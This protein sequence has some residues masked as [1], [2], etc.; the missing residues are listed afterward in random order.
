M[1]A[2]RRLHALSSRE[3]PTPQEKHSFSIMTTAAND[4]MSKILYRMPGILEA[5]DIE[6]WLNS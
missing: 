6:E 1:R 4:F 5:K 2:M 3:N